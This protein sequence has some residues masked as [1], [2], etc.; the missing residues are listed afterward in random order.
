MGLGRGRSTC[1]PSRAAPAAT[2]S[3]GADPQTLVERHFILAVPF[4]WVRGQLRSREARD[5][6]T[7]LMLTAVGG[8][9]AHARPPGVSPGQSQTTGPEVSGW[10]GWAIL[11]EKCLPSTLLPEAQPWGWS[12]TPA[13][14][15]HKDGA[16]GQQVG[17]KGGA[18]VKDPPPLARAEQGHNRPR[19]AGGG[20]MTHLRDRR[21]EP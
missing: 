5:R 19:G 16:W 20:R 3:L 14:Q 13:G 18:G 21:P 4:R 12:Q 15:M 9:G 17:T 2:P 11:S 6:P 1:T 8:G 10:L 7:P